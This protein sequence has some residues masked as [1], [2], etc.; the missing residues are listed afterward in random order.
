M[1]DEAQNTTTA[2]MRIFLTRLGGGSRMV[3]SGDPTQIDLKRGQMSGLKDA[4]E[5]LEGVEGID[6]VRF[7]EADVI[8][9]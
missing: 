4:L 5:T 8:R 9:H 1:L 2:Q 3:I 6:V 7:T